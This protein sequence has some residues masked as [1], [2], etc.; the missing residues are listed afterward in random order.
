MAE[1]ENLLTEVTVY[2]KPNSKWYRSPLMDVTVEFT[3]DHE[4]KSFQIDYTEKLKA[5]SLT[6]IDFKMKD[7]V[8]DEGE[9]TPTKNLAPMV[10]GER[11]EQT[12]YLAET[13]DKASKHL[14]API[15]EFILDKLTSRQAHLS[16]LS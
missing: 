3:D 10:I 16:I 7:Y 15:R 9:Q 4:I 14:P 11:K 13:F 5:Y 6:W 1:S 12:P 8:I 2:S